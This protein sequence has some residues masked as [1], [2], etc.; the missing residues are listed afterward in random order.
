MNGIN[1]KVFGAFN[2]YSQNVLEF[3]SFTDLD[4][5][6]TNVF[7]QQLDANIPLNFL[8]SVSMTDN[9]LKKTSMNKWDTVA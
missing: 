9:I 5:K 2:F 1:N 4:N 3:L 6:M 8:G 7:D